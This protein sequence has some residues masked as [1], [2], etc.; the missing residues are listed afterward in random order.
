MDMTASLTDLPGPPDPTWG[1]TIIVVDSS[2]LARRTRETLE[3][4]PARIMLTADSVASKKMF[5]IAAQTGW[6]ALVEPYTPEELLFRA[7]RL[8]CG[9]GDVHKAK[10]LASSDAGILRPDKLAGEY[11]DMT[12][13]IVEYL[14]AGVILLD[15][16][17]KILSVNSHG[18]SILGSKQDELVG[19]DVIRL[20]HIQ[21]RDHLWKA[22]R[23][24]ES[25]TRVEHRLPLPSGEI[26][27]LGL[28]TAPYGLP[29][30]KDA[31]I[32]LIY[33]DISKKKR[34]QEQ[35]RRTDQLAVLG[36]MA[37]GIAHE[38]RN[39]LA[40]ILSGVEILATLP[41][42]DER[43]LRHRET[44]VQQI[45]RLNGIVSDLLILGRPASPIKK[46]C[47]VLQPVNR[48]LDTVATRALE[49]GVNT[50]VH[51]PTGLP[52]LLAD[53]GKIEQVLLNLFLNALE[54]MPKGGD[55]VIRAA[56]REDR[57]MIELQVTDT[58]IG[59][60]PES[61]PHVF[62]PFFS[63]RAEGSGLGLSICNRIIAD[64]QGQ[65]ELTSIEGKGT[66][67][68]IELPVAL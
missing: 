22:L 12:S 66:T 35:L 38:I 3:K 26:V 65:L 68:T 44:I 59:V 62:A 16:Q 8:D 53:E 9:K 34:L 48:A 39:P 19:K 43:A 42:E 47:P 67:V 2:L 57:H 49:Q 61:M 7:L 1:T 32:V 37:A 4:L 15:R 30:D 55:L 36:S 23:S 64:H 33:Q 5:E 50:R 13:K 31:G 56:E 24:G 14:P 20:F 63:T 17:N 28:S 6:E 45:T 54:A 40:S 27:L 51:I 29:D 10:I 46:A 25:G 58:G 21:R 52:P 11:Q 41:P 60:K 18:A